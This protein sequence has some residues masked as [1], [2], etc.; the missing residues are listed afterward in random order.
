MMR[1]SQTDTTGDAV[2]VCLYLAIPER[3][4]AR[5]EIA[6]R[7]QRLKSLVKTTLDHA[8]TVLSGHLHLDIHHYATAHVVYGNSN[9]GD[10]A[11]RKAIAQQL[12]TAFAPRP[13][14]F[15]EIKW[16]ELTD[17]VATEINA[18]CDLFVI[19]GGGYI[20]LKADGSP[21]HMLER[22]RELDKVRC[23]I[24]AYGIGLNRLMH[25]E[26]C[27]L[28]DLP[29]PTRE[30]IRYLGE[31]CEKISV[32]DTETARL[33]ALHSGKPVALAGDP[34][35]FY[36]P[37]TYPVPARAGG[38]AV[39]GVNLAAH[40]WRAFAVLKPLLPPIVAFL[41][42]IQRD[43][44]LVYL[45]HHQLE[46]PVVEFLRAQGVQFKAVYGTSGDLWEGYAAADFVICQMLHSS[47]FAA[48]S[49]KPFFNIAYDRKNMAFCELL[50]LPDCCLPNSEAGLT[51]LEERFSFLFHNREAFRI[52]LSRRKKA[53]RPVQTRFAA[54]LAAEV[55]Q[56]M[57]PDDF[58]LQEDVAYLPEAGAIVPS[59]R[60]RGADLR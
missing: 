38:R 27:A 32:R 23:P 49:G 13:V 45:Q 46:R 26:V 6:P 20:F 47:V 33:F 35:L 50:G 16:G 31:K 53:L 15:L 9:Q 42:Q 24:F 2:T 60:N 51:A 5:R 54:L 17:R 48:C 39:I 34:A 7:P 8:A 22:V 57:A 3:E 37:N 4:E 28:G 11:I 55:P 21:G 12:T 10:I 19:A 59:I 1:L 58:D 52:A 44:E 14:R 18:R 41:K 30:K 29:E 56:P 43:S 40:G 36:Q 25:E